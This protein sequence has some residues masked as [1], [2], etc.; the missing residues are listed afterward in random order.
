MH[1]TRRQKHMRERWRSEEEVKVK[2]IGYDD[3]E[4][5]TNKRHDQG[6]SDKHSLGRAQWM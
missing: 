1:V 2:V 5:T 3:Q 6:R 4:E